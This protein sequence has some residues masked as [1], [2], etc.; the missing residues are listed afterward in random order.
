MHMIAADVL[1]SVPV[2]VILFAVTFWIFPKNSVPLNIT[3]KSLR[4][5][6]FP[7]IVLSLGAII[8]LIYSLQ[9]GGL[10][11]AWGSAPIIATLTVQGIC[12]LAFIAW[13]VYLTKRGER[14]TM[15][16]VWPARLF[17]GRVIGSAML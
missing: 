17:S 16:P 5:L 1:H 7:G 15:L 2:G 12:W 8:C 6:D 11:L 9:Q 3:F 4:R 13:E 14:S 10:V